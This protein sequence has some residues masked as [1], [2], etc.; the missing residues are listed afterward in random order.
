MKSNENL[1][2][3]LDVTRLLHS[4][5]TNKNKKEFEK[6]LEITMKYADIRGRA[7]FEATMFIPRSDEVH[8]IV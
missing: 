6:T 1:E 3:F 8:R 7:R 4:F 2:H 5:N